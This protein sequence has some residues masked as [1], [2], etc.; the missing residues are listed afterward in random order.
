MKMKLSAEAIKL[1]YDFVVTGTFFFST[2]N[3]ENEKFVLEKAL[4]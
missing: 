2:W 4:N 3:N 1:G